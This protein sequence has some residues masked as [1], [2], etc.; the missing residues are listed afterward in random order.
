MLPAKTPEEIQAVLRTLSG[1]YALTK[2]QRRFPMIMQI[3]SNGIAAVIF[4]GAAMAAREEVFTVFLVLCACGVLIEM[5]YKIMKLFR[6][7]EISPVIIEMRMPLRFLSW[8]IEASD[9]QLIDVELGQ[10]DD[11]LRVVTKTSGKRRLAMPKSTA[12]RLR[13]NSGRGA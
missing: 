11:T 7:S 8:R 13:P 5:S 1:R 6:V 12:S 3:V 9:I 4:I 2:A 10:R